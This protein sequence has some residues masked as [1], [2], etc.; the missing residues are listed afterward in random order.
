MK[1]LKTINTIVFFVILTKSASAQHLQ[2]SNFNVQVDY[3]MTYRPDSNNSDTQHE[4]MELL[5]NDRESIF[6][7]LK[8]YRLDSATYASKTGGN[9]VPFGFI[10]DNFTKIRYYITKFGDS[11]ITRDEYKLAR[12]QDYHYYVEHRKDFDWRVMDDTTT[13]S[14]ILCQ[15]AELDFGGRRWVAWFSPEVPIPDG[16]YKFC[17]LPGLI[18]NIGDSTGSW[19]FDFLGLKSIERQIVPVYD[20]ENPPPFTKKR[21][22]LKEKKYYNENRLTIEEAA[23]TIRYRDNEER[24]A[25]IKVSRERAAKDNN[26]IELLGSED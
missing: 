19:R 11:I 20:R 5:I 25:D 10:S 13:I 21:K 15:R 8:R 3:K 24:A 12:Y 7:S 14:G 26:W 17:G 4:Y 2:Y 9:S 23:G 1:I 16:P 18:L 22:F 6:Q